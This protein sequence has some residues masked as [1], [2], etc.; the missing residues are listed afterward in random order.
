MIQS[1]MKLYNYYTLGELD[2]YGTTQPGKE[3]KGQVK[4]SIFLH[5]KQLSDNSL[6][7]DT[8]YIALTNDN[9]INE[10]YLIEYDNRLLKVLYV[11]V[12]GRYKQL[13]LSDING[14][15]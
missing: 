7:K 5:T 6:Y 3:I 4:L 1:N 12:L 9:D 2:E 8:Q 14:W 10:T 15:I 13:Y 11:N